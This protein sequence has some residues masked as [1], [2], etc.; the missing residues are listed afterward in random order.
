MNVVKEAENLLRTHTLNKQAIHSYEDRL[1]AIKKMVE[2][3][4]GALNLLSEYEILAIELRYFKRLSWTQIAKEMCFSER[5]VKVLAKRGVE[6]FSKAM[7][8]TDEELI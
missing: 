6:R 5:W 4:E 2:C 1:N 8:G 7:F 3:V